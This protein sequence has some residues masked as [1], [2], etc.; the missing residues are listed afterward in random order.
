MN[1]FFSTKLM[2]N[3]FMNHN[4]GLGL[5]ALSMQTAAILIMNKSVLQS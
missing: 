2:T 4:V 3:N 1:S 5:T